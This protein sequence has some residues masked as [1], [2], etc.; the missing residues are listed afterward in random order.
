MIYPIDNSTDPPFRD[1]TK[2]AIEDEFG[3][4]S[5]MTPRDAI[6]VLGAL[7]APHW[8]CSDESE[9]VKKELATRAEILN[10]LDALEN[11]RLEDL[12]VR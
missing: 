8:L 4:M 12:F 9:A 7:A 11:F 3:K 1:I 5:N 2:A 10:D 6:D